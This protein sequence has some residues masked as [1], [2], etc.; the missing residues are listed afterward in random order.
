MDHSQ[1]KID[2]ESKRVLTQDAVVI[3]VNGFAQYEEESFTILRNAPSQVLNSDDPALLEIPLPTSE[4][5]SRIFCADLKDTE[6]IPSGKYILFRMK[7]K[8]EADAGTSALH[9]GQEG[10]STGNFVNENEA[11]A[12]NEKE[13]INSNESVYV[14]S[15]LKFSRFIQITEN[16]FGYAGF[17]FTHLKKAFHQ[18]NIAISSRRLKALVYRGVQN[19]TITKLHGTKM[20]KLTE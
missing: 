19:G 16:I 1:K 17:S 5:A 2:V 8:S 20:Y 6:G 10:S 12:P 18:C 4:L 13:M 9:L 3:K 15:N 14:K 11:T 7:E